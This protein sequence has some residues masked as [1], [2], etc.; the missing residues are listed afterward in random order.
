MTKAQA[1]ARKLGLDVDVLEI[2]RVEDI[3]SA[4]ETLKS[5]VQALYVCPDPLVN[6]NHARIN[7]Q[8][9]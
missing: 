8:P 7:D 1:A 4:F 5:G 9:R 6:A 2:R 3:A